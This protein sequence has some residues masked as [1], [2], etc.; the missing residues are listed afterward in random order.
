MS[1]PKLKA[2]LYVHAAIRRCG[3]QALP[4]VVV[5]KGDD[6]SGTVVV[7][8]LQ[9]GDQCRVYTQVRDA[10]GRLGWMCATGPQA[11]SE[12]R[13]EAYVARACAVDDD[14]WVLDVESADG[15]APFLE[16]LFGA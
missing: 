6:D 9:G 12:G 10:D 1:E 3:L 13:G 4:A 8:V 14:V 11:V 15:L 7:R 5:K 16:P 2:K